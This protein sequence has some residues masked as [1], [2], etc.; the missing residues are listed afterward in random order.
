MLVTLG[1]KAIRESE[2]VFLVYRI[3]H[4][5]HRT[6]DYFIFQRSDPQRTSFSA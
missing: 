3:Q 1:P 2:E 4:R 5:D 6:L